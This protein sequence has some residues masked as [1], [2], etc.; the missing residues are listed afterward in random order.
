M[1]K[2]TRKCPRCQDELA[3]IENGTVYI[4]LSPVHAKVTAPVAKATHPA[5]EG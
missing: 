2:Q 5:K 3:F 1:T 4:C